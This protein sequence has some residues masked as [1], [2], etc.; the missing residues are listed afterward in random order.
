[1]A[2]PFIIQVEKLY[3][4]PQSRLIKRDLKALMGTLSK[5]SLMANYSN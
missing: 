4:S 3:K 1:M 5:A 2:C